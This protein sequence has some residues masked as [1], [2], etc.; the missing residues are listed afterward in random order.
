MTALTESQMVG[1]ETIQILNLA[2]SHLVT[3]AIRK[4]AQDETIKREID[5]FLWA[6]KEMTKIVEEENF[7]MGWVRKTFNGFESHFLQLMSKAFLYD[8]ITTQMILEM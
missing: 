8:Q 2:A 6:H 3:K 1:L 7:D 4:S 5:R